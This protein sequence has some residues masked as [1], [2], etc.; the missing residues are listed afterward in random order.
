MTIPVGGIVEFDGVAALSTAVGGVEVCVA[1]R[2]DDAYT[3]PP[4]RRRHALPL[5]L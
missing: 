4:P 5:R 3:G 2:I 1:D